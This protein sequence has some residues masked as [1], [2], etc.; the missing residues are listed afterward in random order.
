M[1][2]KAKRQSFFEIVGGNAPALTH[3]SAHASHHV[4]PSQPSSAG[5]VPPPLDPV[6][7]FVLSLNSNPYIIG[8]LYLFLN[9][10]GRYL[11]MELTKQQEAFLSRPYLRPFILFAVLFIATRNI[12]V[13]FWCSLGLLATLWFI[14]NENHVMCLIPG[15]RTTDDE[16]KKEQEQS[17]ENN[18]KKLQK[19]DETK[20]HEEEASLQHMEHA[21]H[22]SEP[23]HVENNP[24]MTTH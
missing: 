6:S 7:S 17:Y 23:N 8:I 15:W 24:K 5:F 10:S 9:L 14:A 18:M 12:A 16:K 13:A 21:V 22:S 2:R 11:P 1:P 19:K 4:N 3:A 20:S